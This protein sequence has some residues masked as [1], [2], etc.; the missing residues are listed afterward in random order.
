MGAQIPMAGILDQYHFVPQS[1][2]GGLKGS[3]FPIGYR[4]IVSSD[5]GILGDRSSANLVLR[6]DPPDVLIQRHGVVQLLLGH[7]LCKEG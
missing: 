3:P 6:G 2:S 1:R 5:T 4:Q 7:G